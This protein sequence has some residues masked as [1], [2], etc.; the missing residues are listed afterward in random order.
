MLSKGATGKHVQHANP[1]WSVFKSAGSGYL[2]VFGR[3]DEA[4]TTILVEG[5]VGGFGAVRCSF[6]RRAQVDRFGPVC[7]RHENGFFLLE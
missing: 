6:G 2:P 7:R 3:F 5:K 1:F 4:Y